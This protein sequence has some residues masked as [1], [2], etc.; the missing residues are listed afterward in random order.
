MASFHIFQ[1]FLQFE[2]GDYS[3][4]RWLFTIIHRISHNIFSLCNKE[5]PSW[6]YDAAA[7]N[8]NE[9]NPTQNFFIGRFSVVFIPHPFKSSDHYSKTH[10]PLQETQVVNGSASC[11]FLA[12]FFYLNVK[13]FLLATVI[14]SLGKILLLLL[15]YLIFLSSNKE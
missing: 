4:R 1:F 9:W 3:D 8:N 15:C 14:E 6:Y 10:H 13:V 7:W 2:S 5:M 12:N 11:R